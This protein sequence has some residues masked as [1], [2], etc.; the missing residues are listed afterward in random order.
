MDP[1]NVFVNLF[2]SEIFADFP[3]GP[4]GGA[5]APPRTSP[6]QIC[7]WDFP[8]RTLLFRRAGDVFVNLFG[9]YMMKSALI[10][11]VC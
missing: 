10:R 6:L 7:F 2:P 9:S 8:P 3:P 4:V 11:F 1:L 5:A